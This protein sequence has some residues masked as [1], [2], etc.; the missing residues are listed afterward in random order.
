MHTR[1]HTPTTPMAD[2]DLLRQVLEAHWDEFTPTGPVAWVPPPD[3]D[4]GGDGDGD[5]DGS[6]DGGNGGGD[7]DAGDGNGNGDGDGDDAGDGDGE[8]DHAAAERAALNRRLNEETKARKKAERELARRE[9]EDKEASGEYKQ[10]YEDSQ[11]EVEGLKAQIKDGAFDRSVHAVA[12]RMKFRNPALAPKLVDSSLKDNAVDE[13]GDV[14]EKLVERELKKLVAAD[15]YLVE[16]EK[17]GQGNVKGDETTRTTTERDGEDYKF[18]PRGKMSRGRRSRA[19]AG[20]GGG[21]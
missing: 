12:T 1:T 15:R 17:S 8:D 5:G 18:D 14:D 3:D 13:D 10:M 16:E 19:G 21:E 4:D 2:V 6:G 9:R 7:G 11:K 20:V